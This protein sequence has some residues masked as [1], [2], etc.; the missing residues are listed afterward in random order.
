MVKRL[1]I[2]TFLISLL[3]S[4]TSG[5]APFRDFAWDRLTVEDEMRQIWNELK[6]SDVDYIDVATIKYSGG[7][8]DTVS[9]FSLRI[10]DEGYRQDIPRSEKALAEYEY[11]A[12]GKRILK[13]V[14][15]ADKRL[16]WEIKYYYKDG[17][18]AKKE[19][20]VNGGLDGIC[21]Y[22][23]NE[24]G[25]RARKDYYNSKKQKTREVSYTYQYD[26]QGHWILRQS[27]IKGRLH[28]AT[29]RELNYR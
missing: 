1:F 6:N 20:Y 29:I 5:D 28:K 11:D 18:L 27:H 13:K 19:G 16:L 4:C 2:F 22:E 26:E 10:S 25:L 12:E 8:Q 21:T 9:R 7:R 24:K 14:F 15:D 23:Y 17:L 3:G